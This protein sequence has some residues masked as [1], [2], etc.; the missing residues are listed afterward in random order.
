MQ[1]IVCVMY[2]E[3]WKQRTVRIGYYILMLC[4]KTYLLY[5]SFFTFYL[6]IS[7]KIDLN[8]YYFPYELIVPKLIIECS[9][10]YFRIKAG[11]ANRSLF[12]WESTL[13]II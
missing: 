11:N 10:I 5:A 2:R 3:E 7:L 13:A 4:H 8:R 9:M 12:A 1:Y 6:N